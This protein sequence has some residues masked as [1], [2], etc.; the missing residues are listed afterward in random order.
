MPDEILDDISFQDE[1]E[2]IHDEELERQL[3]SF[4]QRRSD[5]YVN[6]W[7][8]GEPISFNLLK[9]IVGLPWLLYRKMYWVFFVFFIIGFLL[10][11]FKHLF[12]IIP[13]FALIYCII[14]F[15][16]LNF[17]DT[18]AILVGTLPVIAIC[19][20]YSKKVYLSY[21]KGRINTLKIKRGYDDLTHHL[22]KNGGT[23]GAL[24]AILLLVLFLQMF[25]KLSVGMNPILTF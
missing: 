11:G 23:E 13:D 17:L 15:P 24:P 4:I 14:N 9:M 2:P 22:M 1:D 10:L 20:L 18:L 6:H 12:F 8:S 3:H 21:V 19:G 5:Q 25:S 16:S 7:K